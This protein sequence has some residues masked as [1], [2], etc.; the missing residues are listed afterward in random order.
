MK[1]SLLGLA[2]NATQNK[3][4]S[5][6]GDA[7]AGIQNN[8]ENFYGGSSSVDLFVVDV[9][10]NNLAI[11]LDGGE[12]IAGIQTNIK[13]ANNSGVIINGLTSGNRAVVY[14]NGSLPQ[15]AVSGIETNIVELE[16]S[17]VQIIANSDG[18][19]A[20][21]YH[22]DPNGGS[23]AISGT[24]LTIG[25]VKDSNLKVNA[26]ATDNHAFAV[27]GDAISG[28]L[29]E[30]INS[31]GNFTY[32]IDTRTYGNTAESIYGDAITYSVVSL[33]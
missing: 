10:Q 32:D 13:T 7:I 3:A 29:I 12:G 15:S 25:Q 22:F 23:N 2:N 19:S 26:S 8:I 5:T 6:E 1:S 18:N 24:K 21:N 17:D 27:H 16:N 11:V 31:T 14:G 20:Y 28:N 33:P 30:V 9:A 4:T